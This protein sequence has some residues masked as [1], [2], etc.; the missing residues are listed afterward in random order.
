MLTTITTT[1]R[2]RSAAMLKPSDA[3]EEA[4]KDTRSIPS[5]RKTRGFAISALL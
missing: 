1:E 2:Q 3:R 5:S 4:L